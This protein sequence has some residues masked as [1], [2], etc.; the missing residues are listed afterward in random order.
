MKA[1]RNLGNEKACAQAEPCYNRA[2]LENPPYTVKKKMRV[3]S[4]ASLTRSVILDD[5]QGA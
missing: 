5:F 3:R 1:L 4:P 2:R